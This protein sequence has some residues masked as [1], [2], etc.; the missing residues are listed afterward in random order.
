MNTLNVQ[1]NSFEYIQLIYCNTSVVSTTRDASLKHS[2]NNKLIDKQIH[3][4]RVQK[5]CLYKLI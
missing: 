2:T 3:Y 1:K 4:H 5:S